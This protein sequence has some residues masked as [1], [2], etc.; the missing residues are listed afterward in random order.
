MVRSRG[1]NVKTATIS[2]FKVIP[3]DRST[4]LHHLLSISFFQTQIQVL[5]WVE[6]MAHDPH[7]P[8]H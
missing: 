4:L 3:P 2:S 7:L 5:K 8:N 1:H 6:W